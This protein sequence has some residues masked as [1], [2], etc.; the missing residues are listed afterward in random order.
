MEQWNNGL[1]YFLFPSPSFQYSI[2][3]RAVFGGGY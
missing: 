1:I 3:P 2:I